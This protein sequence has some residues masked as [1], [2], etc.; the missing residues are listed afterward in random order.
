MQ[1][2]NI[3]HLVDSLAD[4]PYYEEDIFETLHSEIAHFQAQGNVL[5]TGDLKGRTGIEPDVIDRQ[6]N[7]HV[8]GQSPLFT[9]A[10]IT[11]RNNLDSEINQSG[12][13]VVHLCRALGLYIVHESIHSCHWQ[14]H[15]CLPPGHHQPL[16]H[17]HHHQPGQPRGPV[18][19]EHK[20]LPHSYEHPMYQQ[21]ALL[22]WKTDKDLDTAP[23][24]S[25]FQPARTSGPQLSST[26]TYTPLDL[27]KLFLPVQTI[28]TLCQNTN[29]QAAKQ[30]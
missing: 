26:S 14:H 9:T 12:R 11:H 30:G 7:N 17:S 21:P 29:K 22:S 25:R 4:S 20:H 18:P 16:H 13:E 27:F 15:P 8:F 1:G 2:Q 3:I 6:G 10:T 23:P 28:P 19:P 24:V 5:L